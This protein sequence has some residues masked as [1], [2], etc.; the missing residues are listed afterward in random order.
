MI[1]PKEKLLEF[2]AKNKFFRAS[3]AEAQTQVSRVYLQRLTREGKLVKTARGLYSLA[4]DDFTETRDVLEVAARVPRCVLCLLSALRFHELTT[5]NPSEIWLSIERGQRVPKVENVPV[6]VFRFAPKVYEAGIEIHKIEGAE[7]KV[8][9][10]AKTVA[11]YFRY[12]REVGFDVALEALRD[13]WTKRKATMDELYHFAE[14]RN[15]KNKM[16]PYLRMLN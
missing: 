8:Y 14:V 11:D 5:Q 3:D 13:A 12:Q 7:I 15:I 10:A 6:R 2:A 1:R 4:G 9:S 16:M